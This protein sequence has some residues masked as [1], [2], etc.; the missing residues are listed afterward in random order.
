[1]TRGCLNAA[2]KQQIISQRHNGHAHFAMMLT[3]LKAIKVERKY[4]L[5]LWFNC[6]N[7]CSKKLCE[8]L[9]WAEDECICCASFEVLRVH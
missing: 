4:L 8:T 7:L 6:D 1:M 5:F 3:A 2:Q 9:S